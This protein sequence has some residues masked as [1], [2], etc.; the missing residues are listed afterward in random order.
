[1]RITTHLS[2]AICRYNYQ[3]IDCLGYWYLRL[4]CTLGTLLNFLTPVYFF[5]GV[6]L[7]LGLPFI[8]LMVGFL[9]SACGEIHGLKVFVTTSRTGE[10][11]TCSIIVDCRWKSPDKVRKIYSFFFNETRLKHWWGRI[12]FV[13]WKKKHFDE[14]YKDERLSL[15]ECIVYTLIGLH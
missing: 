7:L 13:I 12:E 8:F 9:L 11:D 10:Q 6:C 2:S 1:M 3:F 4:F 5:R 15:L 14:L